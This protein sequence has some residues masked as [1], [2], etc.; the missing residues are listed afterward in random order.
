MEKLLTICIPT[1]NRRVWLERAVNGVL[2]YINE[3]VELLICD[4]CSTDDTRE[5]CEQI[6]SAHSIIYHRQE[7]NIGPDGNFLWCLNNAQ[8]KYIQ[9]LADDDY[10]ESGE[11]PK[12]TDILRDKDVAV[13]EINAASE[14]NGVISGNIRANGLREYNANNIHDFIDE[15]GVYLT[16]LS[17]MVF[18][19]DCFHAV[20]QP[21]S[22]KNTNLLQTHIFMEMI[23]RFR[24]ALIIGDVR[25]VSEAE[26]SSGY[27][28]YEVF[29]KNWGEVLFGTG[30]KY[31]LSKKRLTQ[32]YKASLLD[33][34]FG[35]II[36]DRI[37]G[38]PFGTGN[39]FK[40]F[41]P[42]MKYKIAWTKLYPSLILPKKTLKKIIEKKQGH[43]IE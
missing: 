35:A 24:T 28:I 17:T 36:K 9:L 20:A 32:V 22:Y 40:Y 31:G 5:F 18:N 34:V 19:R 33:F 26:N 7:T 14:L 1:Y 42:L 38:I 21:E 13:A 16:F 30:V 6:A 15:T 3:E 37:K 27:N 39:K 43:I 4:N 25:C 11:I 10:Y 23:A 2:P 12:L 8:G 29:I 41:A